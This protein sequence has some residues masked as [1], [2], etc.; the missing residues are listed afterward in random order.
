MEFSATLQTIVSNIY[1]VV[2]KSMKITL[3]C[4]VLQK[5]KNSERRYFLVVSSVV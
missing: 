3:I 1:Y 2:I 4:V 5:K